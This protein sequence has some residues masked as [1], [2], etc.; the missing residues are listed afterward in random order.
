MTS[1][2]GVAAAMGFAPG[3]GETVGHVRREAEAP[4][5]WLGGLGLV[6]AFLTLGLAVHGGHT[7]ALQVARRRERELAVR[8]ALGASDGR[9]VRHVL[10]GAAGTALGGSAVA[11]FL[12]A[13][14]VALLRK[15]IGGV[16][17]L[18]PE[19]YLGVVVLLMGAGLVASAQ[20]AREAVRVEPGLA[21]E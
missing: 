12:G 4:R 16:P 15:V 21:M 9:I 5:G 7:T 3:D 6:L 20:A 14:F 17:P 10:A 18:G 8:R 19:A 2:L 1:A 11:V 13:L